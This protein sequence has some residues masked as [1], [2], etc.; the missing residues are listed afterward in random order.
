MSLFVF[1]FEFEDED[2]STVL[3]AAGGS[4]PGTEDIWFLLFIDDNEDDDDDEDLCADCADGGGCVDR[5]SPTK[6]TS[7]LPPSSE[8]DCCRENCEE[9]LKKKKKIKVKNLLTIPRPCR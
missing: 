3:P 6:V 1:L 5:F 2:D 9:L 4:P 7:F 8:S